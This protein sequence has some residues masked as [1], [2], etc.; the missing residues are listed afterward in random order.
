M[1]KSKWIKKKGI[2]SRMKRYMWKGTEKEDAF[3]RGGKMKIK[4][5]N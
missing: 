4:E 3:H 2:S 1:I 5:L